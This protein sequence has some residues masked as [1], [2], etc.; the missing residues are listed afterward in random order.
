VQL[1]IDAMLWQSQKAD[2]I[3]AD[4]LRS[5]RLQGS[6]ESQIEVNR[7]FQD[8]YEGNAQQIHSI[9]GREHTGQVSNEDRQEREG[10]FRK[11]QLA[12]LF[13]SPTMELGIDISDLN[14]VHL[15]N[16]PPTPANYA[17]RSGRAG[18]SGQEALVITYAS[19]GSGH[20]QY[21]FKRQD[22]MVA[23]VVAPPKL[24]LGN[25]DLIKSHI[26]SIWLAHTGQDLKESMNQILDLDLD[27]YPLKDSVRS[28]LTLTAPGSAKIAADSYGNPAK[29][30]RI[31]E[32]GTMITRRRERITCDEEERLKYGY[33]VTTHF[34]YA[35]QKQETATVSAQDGTQLLRLTYGETARI[36]RIN[37]GL[38]RNKQERGFKLDAKG[39]VWGDSK[40]DEA[41]DNLQTEV[42]LMVDDTCNILVVEP[43]NWSLD[44]DAKKRRVGK[45]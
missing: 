27:G 22:Q 44:Y 31:L 32:M 25:Q 7:F 21:F 39:G 1:R 3:P 28:Q 45:K 11:G 16:V 34:R 17:Q 14:A 33:N 41:L 4:P 2:K 8:F 19:V 9:E 20:D 24:E 15:R 26:Y 40:N 5:K 23:G 43:V 18:R 35:S 37:R 10:K 6:A 12:S 42:N 30:N 38:R 36:W 29:L 13:C